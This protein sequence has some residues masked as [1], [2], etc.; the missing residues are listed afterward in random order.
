MISGY[1]LDPAQ[2]ISLDFSD[3]ELEFLPYFLTSERVHIE[4]IPEKDKDWIVAESL[5]SFYVALEFIEGFQQEIIVEGDA[6]D[7]IE[8]QIEPHYVIFNRLRNK[9]SKTSYIMES[10]VIETIT[11][12]GICHPN[13]SREWTL[14]QIVRANFYDFLTLQNMYPNWIN[15]EGFVEA[16]KEFDLELIN[17]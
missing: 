3:L 14:D 9:N 1:S 17:A 10:E 6:G 2:N 7:G 15:H 12:M 13:M 16:L 8:I 4:W 5:K 11:G